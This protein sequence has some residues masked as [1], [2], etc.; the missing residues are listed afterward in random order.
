MVLAASAIDRTTLHTSTTVLL[1]FQSLLNLQIDIYID[2]W[3]DRYG[4][5][6]KETREREREEE[7]FARVCVY[8]YQF[9]LLYPVYCS[10]C[11]KMKSSTDELNEVSKQATRSETKLSAH[12]NL[13][14]EFHTLLHVWSARNPFCSTSSRWS[15]CT[16][17]TILLSPFRSTSENF[18][19][20]VDH[21]ETNRSSSIFLL[22]SL[23]LSLLCLCVCVFHLL[24]HLAHSRGNLGKIKLIPQ[25]SREVLPR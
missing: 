11:Y 7:L 4:E 2:Y 18:F 14:F 6:R 24:L 10:H 23:S 20:F 1:S 12:W 19:L 9:V 5:R 21:R 15:F 22:L 16:A 3:R 13:M 8:R 17:I 25:W